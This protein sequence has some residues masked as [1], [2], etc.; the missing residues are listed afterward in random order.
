VA[1][2]R[3]PPS[4]APELVDRVFSC[5]RCWAVV[6]VDDPDDPACPRVDPT[7]PER[8]EIV[9]RFGRHLDD[10]CA[11]GVN[12]GGPHRC[13]WPTLR[14]KVVAAIVRALSWAS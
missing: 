8:A 4:E 3:T 13:A 11:W 1:E 10:P 2:R 5:S 6:L 9:G 7:I 12:P 14:Q